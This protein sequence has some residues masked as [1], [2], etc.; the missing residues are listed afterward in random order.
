MAGKK[1][2]DHK[3]TEAPATE[4]APAAEG[5]EGAVIETGKKKGPPIKLILMIV[6]PLLLIGGIVGGLFAA[7]ILGGSKDAKQD[8]ATAADGDHAADGHDDKADKKDKDKARRM[9]TAKKKPKPI[10]KKANTVKMVRKARPL[11][12]FISICRIFWLTWIPVRAAK[13]RC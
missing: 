3:A 5:A 4:G 6:V 1:D 11:A 2:K 9:S 7:G 8:E 13:P 12:R 10:K